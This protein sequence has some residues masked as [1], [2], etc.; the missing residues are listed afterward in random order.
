MFIYFLVRTIKVQLRRSEK[1]A[2][3]YDEIDEANDWAAQSSH[4]VVLG[5]WR[6]AWG[7]WGRKKKP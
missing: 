5:T 3:R 1:D 6:R 4:Q 2:G 7:S